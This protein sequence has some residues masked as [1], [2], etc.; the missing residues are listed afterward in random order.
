[1]VQV[2][3]NYLKLKAGYLFPEIARRVKAFSEANPDAALIRLGIGDVTE[4]LPE[5]CRTA[6]K[7]AIDAMGTAEGFRGYG[8]EQ[9]YA[10]LREAIASH[11]F[12]ARGCSISAEEIFI[13]DGSKCDSSNILDILGPGNR[14][15][16]TDPVYPVYVDSNVMAGHTG[17]AD[18]RGRYGGLTYLPITAE[19][20]FSPAIP[21]E[22]VDLIYLCFPNNPTGAVAGRGELK[23]WVDYARA[24][25][26]LILFDAAYEAFIQDPELPHSIFEIDGARECAIE[27][28]S[29]SKNAGFTGTRC[30][31]T[32]VPRGLTGRTAAGEEVE[33]WPLWNRRQSTKF[34]GV[35]Y[36][37][38]RGAEAVYSPEGQAQVN[39]LV[40][41]Y[42]DNAALIRRELSAAGISVHGGEH[43]PYV[44][45]RAPEGLDS[46]DFFDQLLQKAHVVGTPGS[47]FGAA[48]EGY[49]RLSAFNSRANVEEA[50]QRIRNL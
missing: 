34:N 26:S 14:I 18:E 17:P 1:M 13:S 45:L 23:A 22:P 47:G 6:M 33:L 24:H 28:R 46:W 19:N 50:M 39:R 35:S 20:G 42:M 15:A 16:V 31:L 9:G 30:A 38:Q 11:D 21:D 40:R 12:Q 8:P 5:A 25:G 4:P 43:A 37:V 10:W 29:F 2:N 27:F 49:F 48:G 7:N 36:P 32:V 41:F 3:E 44:W